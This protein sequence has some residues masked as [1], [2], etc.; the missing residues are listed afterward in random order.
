MKM[1]KTLDLSAG[2]LATLEELQALHWPDEALAEVAAITERWAR[3]HEE[4]LV[5]VPHIHLMAHHYVNCHGD[6]AQHRA[7]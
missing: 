4:L 6:P 7:P 1:M 5:L 3:A 2:A